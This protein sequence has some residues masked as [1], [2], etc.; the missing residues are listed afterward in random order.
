[1]EA[2]LSEPPRDAYALAMA[3]KLLEAI[4]DAGSYAR[5]LVSLGHPEG[6]GLAEQLRALQQQARDLARK[7]AFKAPLSG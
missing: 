6:D 2:V 4:D 1:M 3:W 7:L 5:R